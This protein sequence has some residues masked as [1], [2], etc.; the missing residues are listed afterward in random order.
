MCSS[1]VPIT[2]K[3]EVKDGSNQAVL[4]QFNHDRCKT[5]KFCGF[6]AH[7]EQS[8]HTHKK[9][10]AASQLWEVPGSSRRRKEEIFLLKPTDF[11]GRRDM[12]VPSPERVASK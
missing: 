5:S 6:M 3:K 10:A 7:R 12:A 4:I 8:F 9:E 2:L 11:L 1:C